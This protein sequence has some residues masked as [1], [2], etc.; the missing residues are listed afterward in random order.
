MALTNTQYDQ[1]M[2]TYQQKQFR[3]QHILEERIKALYEKVPVLEELDEQIRSVSMQAAR[4]RIAGSGAAPSPSGSAMEADL[5]GQIE[6]LRRQKDMAIRAAGFDPDALLPP[7]DCPDCRDTGYIDGKRCHCLIQASIDLI[8]AQ[9]HLTDR[10]REENF[11]HF[12][13]D[14]YSQDKIN[15]D[16]GKSSYET[17]KEALAFC[18]S[19]VDNFARDG[20]NLILIG[21]PGVGKTFLTNCIANALMPRSHSVIYFTAFQL[22]KTFEDAAFKRDEA[23]SREFDNIFNCDLLII[24]DLGAEMNNSFTDSK[25]FELINERLLRKKSTVISSNLDMGQLRDIYSDRTYSRLASN[26][27]FLRL[28][29][30]DIRVLKQIEQAQT[31][32]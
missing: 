2:R 31:P 13:L 32:Q 16:S 29:G 3:N 22:L 30:Q 11:D 6:E 24:D 18:R 20:G 23:A 28:Y 26:Y 8:Y 1:L 25:F 9:S 4:S 15:P 7:Y 27:S 21:P 19:Y 12:R 5:H 14:Y 17:A 10:I